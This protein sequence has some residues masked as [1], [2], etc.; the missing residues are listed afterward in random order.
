MLILFDFIWHIIHVGR[1]TDLKWAV[2]VRINFPRRNVF[3]VGTANA[4][5]LDDLTSSNHFT[6]HIMC[7]LA[8]SR[9]V[10]R[11]SLKSYVKPLQ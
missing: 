10:M 5:V 4:L 7:I 6:V 8:K 11:N 2:Q 9:Y 3:A 1:W